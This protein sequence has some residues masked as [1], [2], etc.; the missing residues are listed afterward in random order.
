MIYLKKRFFE[1]FA[2][3]VNMILVNRNR[4]LKWNSKIKLNY[5]RGF[6]WRIIGV[7][8]ST[9]LIRYNVVYT[10]IGSK[11]SYDNAFIFRKGE[12]IKLVERMNNLI[13]SYY[14][15]KWER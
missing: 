6:A 4:L 3:E 11:F 13:D 1:E 2:C 15:D 10:H 7:E 5:Y 8:T 12:E 14:G 9:N